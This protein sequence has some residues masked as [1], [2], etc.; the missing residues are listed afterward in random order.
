LPANRQDDPFGLSRQGGDAPLWALSAQV[1][2]YAAAGEMLSV[3]TVFSKDT[4]TF[5]AMCIDTERNGF[6][7]VRSMRRSLFF[8]G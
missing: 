4:S 5:Y 6:I 3:N 8:W 2:A 1:R 7:Q